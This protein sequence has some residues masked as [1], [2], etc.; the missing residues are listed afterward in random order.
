MDT[1]MI[2][3]LQRDAVRR[4]LEHNS[5]DVD[6]ISN[7]LAALGLTGD[8][9]PAKVTKVTKGKGKGRKPKGDSSG[10]DGETKPKEK[11]APSA[12]NL[13]VKEH[14]TAE[15]EKLIAN[16][17]DKKDATKQAMGKVG[18]L[19]KAHKAQLAEAAEE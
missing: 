13:F 2:A 19:W 6:A 8:G 12:Y 16:G 17:T 14:L 7:T 3:S 11:R 15:K 9:A 4:A 1:Q 18:E 5:V 10:S